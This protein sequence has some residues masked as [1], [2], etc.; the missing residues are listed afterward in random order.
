ML[1]ARQ[2]ATL[3]LSE[4]ARVRNREVGFIFQS[5]NLIGDLT[6]FENVELPLTYRDGMGKAERR[7]RGGPPAAEGPGAVGAGAG[8]VRA[9]APGCA[10]GGHARP[11]SC[12]GE[13]RVR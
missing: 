5:F 9:T 13:H 2:V 6:V 8:P 4:R 11:R 3:S 10:A 12:G 1:N 7:D